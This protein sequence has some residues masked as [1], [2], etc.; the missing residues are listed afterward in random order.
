[1]EMKGWRQEKEL[2]DSK[3]KYLLYPNVV[4]VDVLNAKIGDFVQ[5]G[6]GKSDYYVNNKYPMMPLKGNSEMFFF[7]ESKNGKTLW[8]AKMPL[9]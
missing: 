8:F 7:G 9:Q 6:Q 2:G 5:F 4:I 3:Y 1:M